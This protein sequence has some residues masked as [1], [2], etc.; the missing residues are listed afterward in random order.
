MIIGLF[1]F[2]GGP[3]D[4][5]RVPVPKGTESIVIRSSAST[6]CT[7]QMEEV[8]EGPKVRKVFRFMEVSK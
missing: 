6:T 8:H 1:E 3:L 2:M 4:G 7:Y 5:L